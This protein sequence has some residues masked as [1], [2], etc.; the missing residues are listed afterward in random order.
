VCSPWM[1][2]VRPY[3]DLIKRELIERHVSDTLLTPAVQIENHVK[4][5]GSVFREMLSHW[6]FYRLLYLEVKTS[7]IRKINNIP[8]LREIIL[9]D[10]YTDLEIQFLIESLYGGFYC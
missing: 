8:N 3:V 2:C 5:R 6:A 10:L 7:N 1:V 9:C 4:R